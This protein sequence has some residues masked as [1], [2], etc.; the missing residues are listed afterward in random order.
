MVTRTSPMVVLP[1]LPV[2]QQAAAALRRCG[3]RS[4]DGVAGR[5]ANADG[6]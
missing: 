4:Y 3:P 5:A 2:R 1:F 6:S